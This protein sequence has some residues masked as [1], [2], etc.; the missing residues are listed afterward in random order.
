MGC[1]CGDGASS[2]IQPNQKFRSTGTCSSCSDHCAECC[3]DLGSGKDAC[4]ELL[5]YNQRYIA[6][7]ACMVENVNVSDPCIL[8]SFLRRY[9]ENTSCLFYNLIRQI[10]PA[11]DSKSNRMDGSDPELYEAGPENFL[12]PEEE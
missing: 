1:A 4:K 7:M 10:C 9:I 6:E 3:P 12:E 11:D 5:D 8:T 2:P